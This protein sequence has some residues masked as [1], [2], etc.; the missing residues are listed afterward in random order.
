[1]ARIKLNTNLSPLKNTLE[2]IIAKDADEGPNSVIKAY[3]AEQEIDLQTDLTTLQAAIVHHNNQ[4]TFKRQ[5]ESF[6]ERRNNTMKPVVTHLRGIAQFLKKLYAPAFVQLGNWGFHVL[7]TGK[8]ILPRNVDDRHKLIEAI[9]EKHDSYTTSASPLLAYLIEQEI[10]LADDASKMAEAASYHQQSEAKSKEA[11]S[12]T[13]QRN[14]AAQP[15]IKNIRGIADFL[16]KIYR[17]NPHALAAWGIAVEASPRKAREQTSKINPEQKKTITGVVIG[18]TINN[19]GP[20]AVHIYKARKIAGTPVVLPPNKGFQ[21]PKGFSVI[22]IVNP[23]STQ[24][25]VI[26]VWVNK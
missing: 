22:T 15:V 17:N 23:S 2:A 3:I 12:E 1:M 20:D 10:D 6:V 19:I 18:E 9:K 7:R 5:S 21:V 16:L 4:L 11:E 14:E 13:E 26:K 8:V 25:A 24:K